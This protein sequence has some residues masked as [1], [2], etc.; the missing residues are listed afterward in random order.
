MAIYKTGGNLPPLEQK[1]VTTGGNLPPT[2]VSTTAAPPMS[3]PL[4]AT[5]V[6]PPQNINSAVGVVQGALDG[7]LNNNGTYMQVARQTGLDAARSRGLVNSSIAAGNAQAEAI[8][9]AQPLVNNALD[10]FNRRESQDFVTGRDRTQQGYSLETLAK[11]HGYNLAT[12]NQQQKN[13]LEQ[14]FKS[15]GYN[16]ES[17]RVG[18]SLAETRAQA[19]QLRNLA[20]AKDAAGLQNWLNNENFTREF[21]GN[22]S[23]LPILNSFQLNNM[24]AQLAITDPEAYPPNVVSGITNFL[25]QNMFSILKEY[26]PNL[27]VGGT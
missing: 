14:M 2:P 10:I 15:Q 13:T 7:L 11:Q 24:I 18:A 9:A 8:K 16:L 4:P 21:N 5:P 6:T 3:G 26:F 22:L 25:N 20:L 1:V 23:M 27:V 17:M 19:D 12:M